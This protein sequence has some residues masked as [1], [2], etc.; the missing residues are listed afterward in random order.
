MTEQIAP[1]P[2]LDAQALRLLILE[3]LAVGDTFG[4]FRTALRQKLKEAEASDQ[5]HG[6][7]ARIKPRDLA[8]VIVRK[9]ASPR[10]CSASI[11]DLI[12]DRASPV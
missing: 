5:L 2:T 1:S 10:P 9:A 8:D 3:T 4:T 7:M 6:D 11:P 12:H